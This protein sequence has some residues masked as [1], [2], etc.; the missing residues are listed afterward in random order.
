VYGILLPR[1]L[2][3]AVPVS[4]LLDPESPAPARHEQGDTFVPIDAM[5]PG[6]RKYL[7]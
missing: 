1:P 5:P 3:I 7:Q 4:L 2:A 6:C